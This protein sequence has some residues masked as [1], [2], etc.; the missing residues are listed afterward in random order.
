MKY[1]GNADSTILSVIV[2]IYNAAPFL[3]KCITSITMQTFRDMEIILVDDGSTDN[4]LEIC[5]RY[6][7]MDT[8]IKVISKKMAGLSAQ[9]RQESVR[10]IV[11]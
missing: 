9:E 3:E 1:N 2:P 10:R 8:R 4:S 7:G 6:Q 5:K 11:S